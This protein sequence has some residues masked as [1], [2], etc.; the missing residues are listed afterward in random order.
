LSRFETSLKQK[1]S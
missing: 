1:L